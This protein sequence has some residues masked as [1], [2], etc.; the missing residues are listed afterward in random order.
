MVE[1]F[2]L[3]VHPNL[4]GTAVSDSLLTNFQTGDIAT[5]SVKITNT[6]GGISQGPVTV[7]YFLNPT[8]PANTSAPIELGQIV[9]VAE[10]GHWQ[11]GHPDEVFH[12]RFRCRT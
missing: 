1:Q 11:I 3:N 8:N 7:T 2:N 12:D 10:P 9:H 4:I 6:G 5:E